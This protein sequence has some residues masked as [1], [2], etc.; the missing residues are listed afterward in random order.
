MKGKDFLW[1]S[2]I[3]LIIVIGSSGNPWAARTTG[4]EVVAAEK[5]ADFI[6]SVIEADRT[7]YTTHVVQRMKENEIVKAD[8]NWKGE[9]ALPLP[10]QMLALAGLRVKGKGTGLEH[11]LISLWPI[12]EKNRP[13]S[14]FEIMGLEALAVDPTRPYTSIIR[15]DGRPYFQ[16]IYADKAVSPSC[17]NCHNSHPLSPRQDYKLNDVMGGIVISFPLFQNQNDSEMSSLNA[18]PPDREEQ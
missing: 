15:K 11:R 12:Y 3:T 18:K 2:M 16:A 17:L 4:Q 10:A 8:E 14:K 7:V 13:A 5:V 1:G 6:H 9:V